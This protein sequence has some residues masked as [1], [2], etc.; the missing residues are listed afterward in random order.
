[1]IASRQRSWDHLLAATAI[2]VAFAV[3]VLLASAAVELWVSPNLIRALAG[4]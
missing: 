4:V 2:C 3:P 1:M